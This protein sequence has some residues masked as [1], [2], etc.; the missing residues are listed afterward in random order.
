MKKNIKVFKVVSV[1]R[2]N[3]SYYG[4]PSWH[5]VLLDSNKNMYYAKT[6]SNAAV[7][8]SIGN[9]WVG[10]KKKLTYHFTTSGNMVVD[11]CE[12]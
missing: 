2:G 9:S 1:L 12:K 4:N 5:L 3:N 8:Y 6:A 10:K 11:Y 7:G